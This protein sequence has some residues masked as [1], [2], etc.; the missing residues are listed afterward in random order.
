MIICGSGPRIIRRI[1]EG[2]RWK[3]AGCSII[4]IVLECAG[5][6]RIFRTPDNYLDQ[7]QRALTSASPRRSQMVSNSHGSEVLLILSVC[8]EQWKIRFGI[9]GPMKEQK[10]LSSV[11]YWRARAP[12]NVRSFSWS[13]RSNKCRFLIAENDPAFPRRIGSFRPRR[14]GRVE[15][16]HNREVAGQ[17]VGVSCQLLVPSCE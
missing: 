4:Q 6:V 8:A 2:D 17:R 12:K 3:L 13:S 5:D 14:S 15:D 10:Y 9:V 16:A 11:V 1:D 7:Y